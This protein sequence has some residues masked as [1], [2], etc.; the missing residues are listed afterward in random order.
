M[1]WFFKKEKK[2]KEKNMW[3]TSCANRVR[4]PNS[5]IAQVGL[6]AFGLLAPC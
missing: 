4:C 3:I 1:F 5:T 6:T 2:K